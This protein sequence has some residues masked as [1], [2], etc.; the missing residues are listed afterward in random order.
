MHWINNNARWVLL[1]F[2]L[3]FGAGRV[4]SSVPSAGLVL[5][6]AAVQ[7]VL[8]DAG[9][10]GASKPSFESCDCCAGSSGYAVED[11]SYRDADHS[12]GQLNRCCGDGML[13][14]GTA[15]GGCGRCPVNRCGGCCGQDWS[16]LFLSES[17]SRV[18]DPGRLPRVTP[19]DWSAAQRT[20]RPLLQPPRGV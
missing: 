3:A 2:L 9:V 6:S 11:E 4:W 7:N 1:G 20:L 8:Q 15:S 18:P 17:V 10:A 19:E 12:V 16:S 5:Q 14:H 13:V